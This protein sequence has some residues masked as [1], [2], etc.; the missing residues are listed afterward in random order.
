MSYGIGHRY[1]SN[2]TLLWLWCRL[3]AAAQIRPLAW[4]PPYA[5]YAA[6]VAQKSKKKISSSCATGIN[7]QILLIISD[8]LKFFS[9]F[10][11]F[12]RD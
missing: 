1:G 12:D 6:S 5:G 8:I 10:E 7:F 2:P 9:V 4:E 3:R 11:M